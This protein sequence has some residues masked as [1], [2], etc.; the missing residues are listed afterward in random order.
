MDPVAR[1]KEGTVRTNWQQQEVNRGVAIRAQW[2][3]Y[4]EIMTKKDR[5]RDRGP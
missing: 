2:I 5:R 3:E 4:W 1:G